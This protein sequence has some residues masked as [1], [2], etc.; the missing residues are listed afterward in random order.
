MDFSLKI[1]VKSA[2][3]LFVFLWSQTSFAQ[4]MRELYTIVSY[5]GAFE[6]VELADQVEE[7]SGLINF[8]DR[9]WTINDSQ[10][11]AEIYRIDIETGAVLQTVTIENVENNDW[12]EL[13][14]DDQF[15]YIGDFGNNRGN[16]K[17]L[18]IYRI[19]KKDLPGKKNGKISPEVIRFDY[20]YQKEFTHPENKHN[21][22][23][24][25]MIAFGDS[26]ML[27]SKNRANLKTDLYLLPKSPGEYSIK[28]VESFDSDGLITGA[29]LNNENNI[30]TLV[31]YKDQNPFVFVVKDFKG[32]FSGAGEICRFNFIRLNGSQTEGI[33]WLSDHE[34]CI[35]TEKTKTFN[36]GIYKIDLQKIFNQSSMDW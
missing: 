28:P 9:C 32:S 30:L 1:P 19:S 23:C 8:D 26:L 33:C 10:N 16:R 3:L 22:D 35:S 36:Q 7:P 12:E 34:I 27:F 24:E 17:N 18:A 14:A 6:A 2:V 20:A 13:A 15:I 11:K 21:F 25:A 29:C 5:P 4:Q 31:G